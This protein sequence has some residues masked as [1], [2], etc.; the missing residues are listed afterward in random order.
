MTD[1]HPTIKY[2]FGDDFRNQTANYLCEIIVYVRLSASQQM[3]I[4]RNSCYVMY[5]G[6]IST[7]LEI[8]SK[9]MNKLFGYYT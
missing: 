3:R 7:H 6:V 5:I 8:S 1:E 4:T 9:L 2:S